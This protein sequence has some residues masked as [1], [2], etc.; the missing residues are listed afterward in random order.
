M[1]LQDLSLIAQIVGGA[2]VLASLIFVGIEVRQNSAITRAQVHQQLSDTFTA[3]LETL[4][5][6]ASIVGVGTSSKAGL[7]NMTDEELLRFSFLMAGLFKIWENAFYQHKSGFL[8]ERAW[9]SNVQWLL[10]WYHLPGVRIWWLVRKDL[11]A[12]EFQAFVEACPHPAETRAISARL[13]EAAISR[14]KA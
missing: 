9:Q 8:D 1:T 12:H 14:S 4:A 6:H 11:F 10:T 3:Y 7:A 5:G 13:R 2:A